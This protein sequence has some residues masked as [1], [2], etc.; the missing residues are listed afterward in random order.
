[1]GNQIFPT[2]LAA[3]HNHEPE[4]DKIEKAKNSGNLVYKYIAS[5]GEIPIEVKT[6]YV[7]DVNV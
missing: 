6:E 2:N 5:L 3:G 7:S 1:M 4:Y